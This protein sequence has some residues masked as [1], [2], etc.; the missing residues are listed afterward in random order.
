MTIQRQCI[1]Q[2][3]GCKVRCKGKGQ[4][5]ARGKIRREQAAAQKPHRHLGPI[6]RNRTDRRIA[7][8][9]GQEGLY[10][11]DVLNKAVFGA[12][13]IAAKGGGGALVCARCAANA[14][15]NATGMKGIKGAK[16]LGNHQR[17][18]VWQ[19]HATRSNADGFR[20]R[21]HMRNHDRGGRTGN[22]GHVVMFGQPVPMIAELFGMLGKCQ[23]IMQCITGMLTSIDR[24]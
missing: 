24:A 19:H 8:K 4:A 12:V 5:K 13:H 10:L 21:C 3:V 17:R 20:A 2:H 9:W 11:K 1:H 14:K 22:A 15:V 18:M 7:F 6:S 16:L 23:R